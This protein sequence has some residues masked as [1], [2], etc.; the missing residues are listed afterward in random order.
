MIDP[1]E[2]E[3]GTEFFNF[4]NNLPA[5]VAE[6][7]RLPEEMVD[8]IICD[9]YNSHFSAVYK[10]FISNSKRAPK[11]KVFIYEYFFRKYGT[12]NFSLG[13]LKDFLFSCSSSFLESKRVN[14]FLDLAGLPELRFGNF[15]H[16]NRKE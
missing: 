15:I 13:I 1:K 11:L 16:D 7:R 6:G 8:L 14:N 2:N 9:I 5:F 10:E 3:E 12:R 4:G